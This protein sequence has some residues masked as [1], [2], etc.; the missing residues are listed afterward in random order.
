[1]KKILILG[2][3][4]YYLKTIKTAKRLGYHTIV[5][6]QNPHADGFKESSESIVID[7]KDYAKILEFCKIN[8][9]DGI[10][11]L[12]DF[13]V[14][15]AA[16]VSEKLNLPGIDPNIAKIAINKAKLRNEW[17]IHNQPNPEFDVVNSFRDCL[18]ACH[19]IG[20]P[21]ILKPAVSMGGSRGVIFV[22]STNN[23]KDAYRFATSFY[24][25]KT[26]LVEEYL[27]G[28]E[29][30]GEVLIYNYKAY[31]I[32]VSDKIKSQLP[33]RVDKNIIYPT[34]VRG[35]KLEHLKK[36]IANSVECLKIK[37]GCAHVECCSTEEGQ[38]KLFELGLRPGGG[39][40]PDPIVPFVTGINQIK[41]Y[42]RM[43]MGEPPEETIPK[44]NRACNFHFITPKPGKIKKIVIGKKLLSNPAVLDFAFFPKEGDV[45][46]EIKVGSDR[47]G[48]I[49]VGGNS[50]Q[51][52][53]SMGYDLEKEVKII[54]GYEDEKLGN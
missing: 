16:Y 39:S 12:N 9:V 6:D 4:R 24:S 49:V 23:L 7:I 45:I 53:L 25:D 17:Q 41:E 14:Y 3:S 43:G 50:R 31:V 27:K 29:H 44:I 21:V 15:T 11:A 18:E 47:S 35:E 46:P 51:E 52:V 2:G 5:S 26:I 36:V 20:F 32:A 34:I 33:A 30:S 19:R 40:I 54:T 42:I 22:D 38:V 1:M 10:I 8:C 28:L 13:G 48:F 37:S